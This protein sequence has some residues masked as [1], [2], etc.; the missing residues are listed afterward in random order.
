M[1]VLATAPLIGFL[2][3][4]SWPI[5]QILLQVALGKQPYQST[6][7]MNFLMVR[8]PSQYN[9]ILGRPGICALEVV[10][11]S[12]A[13]RMIKFPTKAGV[14]HI[15]SE[16]ARPLEIQILHKPVTPPQSIE[17]VR[18]AIHP[19]QPEQSVML[20]GGLMEKGKRTMCEAVKV[21]FD[22]FAWKPVDMTGVP[23]TLA[24]YKLGVKEGTPPFRQKKRCQALERSKVM[25]KEVQ[26]LVEAMIMRE[27]L[28][29]ILRYLN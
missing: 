20:G 15:V 21:N 17:G 22:I 8:S 3:E 23:R 2:S 1:L 29:K 4:I 18:V 11:Q 16:R 5:R 28:V 19:E 7:W 27:V 14:A 13:H 6:V 24:L 9:E 12:T 25:N 26:K 10:I